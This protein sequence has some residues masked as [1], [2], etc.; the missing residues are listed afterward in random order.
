[1]KRLDLALIKPSY[2]KLL[3]SGTLSRAYSITI[4]LFQAGALCYPH[5]RASFK[6]V[7]QGTIDSVPE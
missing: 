3:L 1:M 2:Y 4:P 5:F 6:E 7:T